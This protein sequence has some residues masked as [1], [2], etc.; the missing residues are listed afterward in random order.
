[1]LSLHLQRFLQV[2]ALASCVLCTTVA[3]A[4]TANVDLLASTKLHGRGNAD[5]VSA[6]VARVLGH[7]H[8]ARF[9]LALIDD[10]PAPHNGTKSL[11]FVLSDGDGSGDAQKIKVRG[12]SAS[13][14][15]YGVGFYLRNYLGMNFSWERAGGSQTRPLR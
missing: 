10:C 8:A 11:C 1:M 13:E 12:T 6:L 7:D 15:A 2:C 9:D 4:P 5:A 14:V 3:A